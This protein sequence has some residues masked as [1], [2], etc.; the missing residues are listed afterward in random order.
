MIKPGNVVYTHII[1]FEKN[2]LHDHDYAEF[3]YVFEGRSTHLFNGRKTTISAGDACLIMPGVP[4]QFIGGDEKFLHR[5][6]IFRNDYFKSVC[7][8]LSPN[9]YDDLTKGRLNP[10]FSLN[11]EQAGTIENYISKLMI[12]EDDPNKGLIINLLCSYIIGVL[13]EQSLDRSNKYPAWIT[14]L[15]S[16]LNAPENLALDISVITSNFTYSQEHICRSF[17]KHTGTTI[18][19]YFNERKMKYA[20]TL[21]ETTSYSIE[22]I[23]DL[24]N[25]SNISYFY[26]TFKR[27][28]GITPNKLRQKSQSY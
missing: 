2:P 16:M 27:Y 4:H 1:Q 14:R 19:E 24:L 8:F 10:A 11:V 26:R 21:L 15:I 22:Q 13:T 6:I 18:T 7:D 23:G 3:F 12:N 20:K 25:F 5:D 28:Y 17:K 9:L